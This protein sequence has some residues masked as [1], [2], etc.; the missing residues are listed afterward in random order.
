MKLGLNN[1]TLAWAALAVLTTTLA[2]PAA[3]TSISLGGTTTTEGW[4]NLGASAVGPGY[5]T[6]FP[7]AAPWP[8]GLA[9]QTGTIIAPDT[10]AEL[11]RTAGG[12]G[13]GPYF[14]AD[15][16]YHGGISAVPN[17]LGG[18]LAVADATA[19]ADV[20]TVVFQIEITDPLGYSFFNNVW[21]TLTYTAGGTPSLALEADYISL[22]DSESAGSFGGENADRNTWALQWGLP[23]GVTEFTIDWS[24]VQHSQIYALQLDQGTVTATGSVLPPAV[25][26]PASLG[27]LAAGAL[28]LAR[29]RA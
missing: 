25:P 21:P 17:T 18:S 20:R 4:N 23:T 7:G 22:I 3:V 10:R 27:L 1:N 26:E 28:I 11:N 24:S 9:S 29:R 16:I 6:T 15:S 12:A 14:A 8:G 19:L 13:G 5:P 2:A